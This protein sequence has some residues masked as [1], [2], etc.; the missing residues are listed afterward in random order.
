[1]YGAWCVQRQSTIC[2]LLF[3]TSILGVKLNRK[4]MI[5]VLEEEI[6]IYDVSTMKL[7]HTIETNVNPN[8]QS[9]GEGEQA[10]ESG[11][12]GT[13]R[14]SSHVPHRSLARVRQPCAPSRRRPRTRTSPTHRPSHHRP[15]HSLPR[16]MLLHLHNPRRRGTSSCSTPS[17]YPRPT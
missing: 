8:G 14:S 12:K 11:R 6:Y 1:M 3:P 5:V 7:L 15:H 9:E 2:E 10:E 17:P 16:R 13:D 4:R